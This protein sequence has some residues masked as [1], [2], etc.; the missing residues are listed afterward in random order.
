MNYNFSFIYLFDI[1]DD[2]V[3][4]YHI[5]EKLLV[6]ADIYIQQYIHFFTDVY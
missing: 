1:E 2:I 6:L 3:I 4:S 5:G